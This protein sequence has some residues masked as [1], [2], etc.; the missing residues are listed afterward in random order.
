MRDP[1]ILTTD[2][3]DKIFLRRHRANVQELKELHECQSTLLELRRKLDT[4]QKFN[5]KAFKYSSQ[6]R[7]FAS[8]DSSLQGRS[9]LKEFNTLFEA[10][11]AKC[12]KFFK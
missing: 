6:L 5:D 3:L 7:L 11:D 1:E 4:C 10:N 9:C 8:F 12:G 2:E